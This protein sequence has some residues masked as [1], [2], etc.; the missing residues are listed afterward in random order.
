[1]ACDFNAGR[2]IGYPLSEAEKGRIWECVNIGSVHIKDAN[3]M[4]FLMSKN[5][6]NTKSVLTNSFLIMEKKLRIVLFI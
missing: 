5:T 4:N 1:M 2:E 6:R 3:I